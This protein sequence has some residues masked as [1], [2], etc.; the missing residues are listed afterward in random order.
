MERGRQHSRSVMM[1]QECLLLRCMELLYDGEIHDESQ[2]VISMDMDATEYCHR[3][4]G[5]GY[6]TETRAVSASAS[7][8]LLQIKY[9]P[10]CVCNQQLHGHSMCRHELSLPGMMF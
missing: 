3:K 10:Q 5:L 4:V 8:C 1:Y 2:L 7:S 6:C 9:P